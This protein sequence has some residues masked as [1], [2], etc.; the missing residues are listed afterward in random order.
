MKLLNKDSRHVKIVNHKVKKG[1]KMEKNLIID[2]FENEIVICETESKVMI[3]MKR[4]EL[5]LECKE[6]DCIYLN[7]EGIYQIDLEKTKERKE[8]I[9]KKF[10]SLFQ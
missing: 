10:G 3:K 1:Q 4:N 5:P 9:E 6:G 8:L 7:S 2:R